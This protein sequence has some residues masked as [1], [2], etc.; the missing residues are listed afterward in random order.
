M[1]KKMYIGVNGV[2]RKVKTPYVGV[3]GKARKVKAG[4]IGV[5]GVARQFYAKGVPLSTFAVGDTVKLNI[6]GTPTEFIVIH[7]GL[8]SSMYDNSC[9][10]TWLL[11]KNIW[12]DNYW[13]NSGSTG[14][15]VYSSGQMHKTYL[16]VNFI[17]TLDTGVSAIV[18]QAKIP[19]FNGSGT[20]GSVASGSSGLSAK[21]FLLSGYE[22]GLTQSNSSYFPVDGACLDYFASDA[23]NRRIAYL[24][25]VAS[26]WWI[27]SP[28]TKTNNHAWRIESTG[29]YHFYMTYAKSGVRPALILPSETLVPDDLLITG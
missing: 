22:V 1:A 29:S 12:Q 27:R 9:N 25:G 19:Y 14:W 24:N 7:Q 13:S 11:M 16:N 2:A 10:G 28:Y 17:A 8:P 15:N 5:N 21:A 23:T 3:D 26:G 18:K 20:S 4:Y 6:N